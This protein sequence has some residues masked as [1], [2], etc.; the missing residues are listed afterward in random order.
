MQTLAFCR[1]IQAR[2]RNQK[3]VFHPFPQG[4]DA[5]PVQID[6]VAQE[7]AG[8]SVQQA[9]AVTGYHG[10]GDLTIAFRISQQDARGKGKMAKL[11]GQA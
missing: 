7:N 8:Q 10:Q 3:D 5:G 4:I 2:R 6:V 1:I 9:G 11:A